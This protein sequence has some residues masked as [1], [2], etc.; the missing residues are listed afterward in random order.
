MSG[1]KCK[2]RFTELTKSHE[3]YCLGH[4]IQAGIAYYRATGNRTLL[5]AGIRFADYV[6]ENFRSYE[7]SVCYRTS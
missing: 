6:V 2:L 3:D 5:D 7:T 1:T 4:L